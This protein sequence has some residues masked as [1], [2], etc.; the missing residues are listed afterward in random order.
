MAARRNSPSVLQV[1]IFEDGAFLGTDMFA[2]PEVNIGRDPEQCDLVLDSPDVSRL[3]AVFERR[4][5]VLWI[6]DADSTGGIYVNGERV[7]QAEIGP[8]DEIEIGEYALKIKQVRQ[9]RKRTDKAK[10][11]ADSLEDETRIAAAPDQDDPPAEPTTVAGSAARS[12]PPQHSAPAAEPSPSAPAETGKTAPPDRKE[13]RKQ[14]DA[15]AASPRTAAKH[16]PEPA[17]A[18]ARTD[19]Q[20][21][22]KPAPLVDETAQTV[23]DAPAPSAASAAALASAQPD[24]AA[25]QSPKAGKRRRPLAY[26]DAA[27]TAAKGAVSSV[28]RQV[29]SQLA[30]LSGRSSAESAADADHSA[31]PEPQQHRA[32][33]QPEVQIPSGQPV[34]TVEQEEEEDPEALRK[35]PFNLAAAL[36]DSGAAPEAGGADGSPPAVELLVSRDDELQDVK[37]LHPGDRFFIGP[38]AGLLERLRGTDLPTRRCLVKLNKNGQATVEIA[39]DAEGRVEQNGTPAA[40]ETLLQQGKPRRKHNTVRATV[41]HGNSVDFVERGTRYQLRPVAAPSGVQADG[42]KPVW[43]KRLRLSPLDEKAFG[44][45][46]TA[47]L[48]V[49]I[50]VSLL[51][52]GMTA[53]APS[54]P[55]DEFV[56]VKLE[57]D[58]KLEKEPEPPKPQP[59]AKKPTP[60][61]KRRKKVKRRRRAPKNKRRRAGGTSKAKKGVLGLLNKAGS[62]A[63]AGSKSV[64]AAATNLK[65]AKV[66]GS[67]SGY[68]ISGLE[69]KT[70]TSK[71][72]AGGGGG[73]LNT[74]SGNKLL[75]G[76]GGGAGKLKGGG[77]RR[78]RGLVQKRPRAMRSQGQGT[79]GRAK[80]QRVINSHI[81]AIQRCY[82][83]QLL[84]TA[85]LSGKVRAEWIIA[86]DG[87]VKTARQK[88]SSLN[89]TAVVNC[90]LANIR[91]WKFPRPKGGQVVVTY[92]FTF[93]PLGM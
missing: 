37:L 5:G 39:A 27:S 26:I 28:T 50:T 23:A 10:A 93:K 62:S 51:S 20:Q 41:A 13:R 65:A 32:A 30:N 38:R 71:I 4:K 53:P 74:R 1:F 60:K 46:A 19:A 42:P 84:K 78:V 64:T 67:S 33:P 43:W 92:P 36:M 22:P 54:Q 15:E 9:A 83:R 57:E 79:L 29:G 11:P 73:G 48:V 58:M 49:L 25:Q 85:G 90:I 16:S 52:Q 35:P 88:R 21:P 63:A 12:A 18:P 3:H 68:R 91:K 17:A 59:K 86:A 89:S 34:P 77:G 40:L 6:R 24:A 61:K 72:R 55:Q 76:G 45:S 14:R 47:H 81:S 56:E 7:Q 8:L 70:P 80:I 69:G 82:E 75:R 87:S 31:P 2:Q 66:P 44:I